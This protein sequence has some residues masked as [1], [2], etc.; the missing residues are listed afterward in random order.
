MIAVLQDNICATNLDL[1][2]KPQLQ[3]IFNGYEIN[4]SFQIPDRHRG[5]LWLGRTVTYSR[6]TASKKTKETV[7]M[8]TQ[9]QKKGQIIVN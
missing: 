6:S 1:E 4:I 3:L 9:Q 5:W 7:V 2:Y 8:S